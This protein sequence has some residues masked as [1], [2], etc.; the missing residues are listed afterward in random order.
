MAKKLS[1]K[2]LVQGNPFEPTK[3]QGDEFASTIVSIN[4]QIV[5]TIEL[6]KELIVV[7][8]K[9][10][11]QTPFESYD[12][13]IDIETGVNKV[14]K[15]NENLTKLEQERIK[16]SEKLVDLNKEEAEVNEVL[17]EQIKRRNKELKEQAKAALDL[18]EGIKAKTKAE[19]ESLK[20]QK[21]LEKARERLAKLSS[22]EA[23]EI[24][25][26]REEAN[27]LNKEL[28]DQAKA[29]IE[30][31]DKYKI[32]KR[33]TNEAQAE[34]KRLA[35]ELGVN[36]DEAKAALKVFED[37]DDQLREIND[38]ARDGRRNVGRYA[39]SLADL[40]ENVDKAENRLKDIAIQFGATSKQAKASRKELKA[41]RK[42]L[43]EL[44]KQ[45]ENAAKGIGKVQESVDQTKQSIDRLNKTAN[46]LGVIAILVKLFEGLSSAISRS[47]SASKALEKTLGAVGAFFN[48]LL[49]RV[50]KLGPIFLDIFQSLSVSAEKFLLNVELRFAKIQNVFGSNAEEV[51]NLTQKIKD[52]DKESGDRKGF[53]D[54][55]SAFDG[56]GA[57][58][59]AAI[60]ASNAFIDAQF[61]L[62]N[63]T[64]LLTKVLSTP[65]SEIENLRKEAEALGVNLDEI[66]IDSIESILKSSESLIQAEVRLAEAS[67]S[68]VR[69]LEDRAKATKELLQIQG[70]IDAQNVE[71]AKQQ[72]DLA[73]LRV[74]ANK[75]DLAAREEL[76]ETQ[77]A[78]S[79]AEATAERNRLLSLRELKDIEVD[80]IERNLD[81]VIDDFDRRKT[82][83][84]GLIGDETKTFAERQA[85]LIQNQKLTK[86][87]IEDTQEE[88]NKG[89]EAGKAKLDFDE[90]VRINDSKIIA[91]RI[92][93]SGLND[94]LA[95]RALEIIK[96]RLQ[97][98]RDLE[99]SERD[100]NRARIE[101]QEIEED[102][103]LQIEIINAIR[104]E[105][106][107]FNEQLKKLD[108]ERTQNEIDNLIKRLQLI[109]KERQAQREAIQGQIIALGDSN[110]AEKQRLIER[111][112]ALEDATAEELKLRQQLGDK[113]IDQEQ[114]Q[115]EKL[116]EQRKKTQEA[117]SEIATAFANKLF[118]DQLNRLDKELEAT[119]NRTDE[120][121]EL[122][123]NNVEG[124]TENLAFQQKR[125]A[126][127]ERER[128]R[129]R[130]RQEKSKAFLTFLEV[131]SAKA[132]TGDKNAIVNTIFDANVLRAFVQSLPSF[133]KGVESLGTTSNPVD[134]KGG[135][136][137]VAHEGERILPKELNRSLS[138][139]PSNVDLVHTYNLGQAVLNQPI[140]KEAKQKQHDSKILN[141]L[142]EVRDSI[143][144]KPVFM[145]FDYDKMAGVIIDIY[146]AKNKTIRNHKKAVRRH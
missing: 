90:L 128:E 85:L 89:I 72:R 44:E 65:A 46:R 52:L 61:R 38:A 80:I 120:L 9:L 8:T 25:L 43:E 124:A 1:N 75:E 3:S 64:V 42:S 131:A 18:E 146:E 76:A 145:G 29:S 40:R 19:Q 10:V 48:V 119:Q 92:Q 57:S 27:A 54:L 103:Q 53:D 100:L 117:L 7:N 30:V 107:F 122:A 106:I 2:D 23:K 134:S 91:E 137:I 94:R 132:A 87:F 77:L 34:F 56:F 24:A 138:A 59:D 4:E 51:A 6:Q 60:A 66:F 105:R 111:F 58:V 110:D 118:E 109:E 17:R 123:A 35:A 41:S 71:L 136:V 108:E 141:S 115:G 84:E 15:A 13:L 114:K 62:R 63:Q 98:N 86:R 96:E 88:I 68:N 95:G 47:E 126:E 143:D 49:S 33:S 67:E 16:L 78:L 5:K 22:E 101:G 121:R 70:A 83:N 102:I 135:R 140:P 55:I 74:N 79:E 97:F 144:K 12:N 32:L 21:E 39:E 133:D 125:E 116:I 139:D 14:K 31:N 20:T 104:K 142:K 130:K 37:F 36:S 69:S 112:N 45:A 127:I 99:E 28:R 73:Q 81:F 129:T 26:L 50:I 11:K 113:V 82:I 93:Q